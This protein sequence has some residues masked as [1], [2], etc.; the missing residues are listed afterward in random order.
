MLQRPDGTWHARWLQ[1]PGKAKQQSLTALGLTTS[2]ARRQWAIEKAAELKKTATAIS[3]G[4]A[5]AEPTTVTAAVDAFNKAS[6]AKPSTLAGYKPHLE[7]FKEWAPANRIRIVQ[8]V[9]ATHLSAFRDHAVK[10]SVVVSVAGTKRGK[11]TKT[12]RPRAAPT[13]NK[14]LAVVKLFLRWCKDQGMAERLDGDALRERLRPLKV[15]IEAAEILRPPVVKQ[16][17]EA[18]QRHDADKFELTRLEHDGTGKAGTT[19][20]YEPVA[21]FVLLSLLLGTRLSELVGLQWDEVD[22]A[23][24]EVRLAAARTKT[25]RA[26]TITLPETPSALRLLQALRIRGGGDRV[27]PTWTKDA[28]KAARKRLIGDFKAPTFSWQSLRRTC[29]AVLTNA[30]GIYAGASAYRSAKRAGHSVVIADRHYVDLLQ[31][32]AH[33]RTFEAAVGIEDLA[34]QIVD[35]VTGTGAAAETPAVVG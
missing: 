7:Q 3:V 26:R 31:L 11:K 24:G 20:R 29:A 10:L 15:N 9:T 21:P 16:L 32:P 27:F 12:E 34:Q 8:D 13:T 17:L 23:A 4:R 28:A 30:G 2:E 14:L 1:S 19:P 22:L 5:V 25:G 33:A 18:C 6:T 35:A